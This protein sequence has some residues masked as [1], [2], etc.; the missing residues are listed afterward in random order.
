[1]GKLIEMAVHSFAQWVEIIRALGAVGAAPYA[2]SFVVATLA[3]VLAASI[4]LLPGTFLYAYLGSMA[5]DITHIIN[6]EVATSRSAQILTWSGLAVA[7]LTSLFIAPYARSAIN[8]ALHQ[9]PS[10]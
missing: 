9:P 7:L 8:Q 3:F 10:K 2:V 6:G 1:M 5:P 4:G